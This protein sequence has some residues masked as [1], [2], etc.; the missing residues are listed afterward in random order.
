MVFTKDATKATQGYKWDALH[1][2]I[3]LASVMLPYL[4]K[5]RGLWNAYCAVDLLHKSCSGGVS[6]GE[7]HGAQSQELFAI[8]GYVVGVSNTFWSRRNMFKLLP[9][10]FMASLGKWHLGTGS[11]GNG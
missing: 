1:S 6:R 3:F 4:K 2:E 9:K 10:P 11:S 5:W 7:P 8:L